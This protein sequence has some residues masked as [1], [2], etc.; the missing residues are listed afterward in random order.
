[1][2]DRIN[3]AIVGLGFGEE[4]IPI[5]Q[6]HPHANLVAI[7]QRNPEHLAEIGDKWDVAKRY[8][9]FMKLIGDPEVEAVHINSPIDDHAWMSIEALKAGKHVS[10]TV[11]MA[12]T[13]EECRQVVAAQKSSGKKYMMAETTV[14]SREYLFV[15]EMLD[16][17]ELGRLQFV[18]AA[19]HQEMAAG[20]W[21]A[22]WPGM[23]P[24]HYATHCVGPCLAL[25]GKLVE[26]VSC[27]GS[28]RVDDEYA[29]RYGSPFAI[30][31]AHLKL[32][33]SDVH[34][35]ISR[36]LYNTAREYVESF[37]AYGS[38]RTFEWTQLMAEEPVLF[39]GEDAERVPIPDYAHLLPEPIRIFSTKSV[40]DVEVEDESHMS[41]VQGAGHGGSH[42]H[43]AHEFVMSIVEDRDPFPNAV[44]SANWTC[45]G[46]AAHDSALRGGEIVRLPDFTLG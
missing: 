44:T 16:N 12:R 45:A 17:G 15:K 33:D 9:D 4:F 19:H 29:R 23:P 40:F 46:I 21:P 14:Y 5:Y 25:T 32:L 41:F 34:A 27:L 30:E 6:A 26:W 3:V 2:T 28:G 13:V 43:L 7:C 20:D 39:T 1:M 24:M 10:S 38:K 22:Y 37:D 36:S 31:T 35:E 11:P 42:P 18:R 8:T